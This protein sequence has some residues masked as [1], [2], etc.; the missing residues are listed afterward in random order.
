[1]R[2]IKKLKVLG[3]GFD[4]MTIGRRS[5]VRSVPGELNMDK[6]RVLELAQESTRG[7]CTSKV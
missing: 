7:G 6:N 2:S 4:L 5:Y 3:S 1:M